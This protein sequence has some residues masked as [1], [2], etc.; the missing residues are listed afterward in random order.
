MTVF[1]PLQLL[2]PYAAIAASFAPYGTLVWVVSTLAWLGCRPPR[3][4]LL[5]A[6]TGAALIVHLAWTRP[7]WPHQ[8]PAS[9]GSTLTVMS[10]NMYYGWADLSQVAAEVERV[11]PDIVVLQEVTIQSV[12]GIEA[13][14]WR[15]R[16]PHR[17]GRPAADW[18]ATNMLVF[19]RYPLH[20]IA[21]A[22]ED[23]PIVVLRADVPGGP[24]T[25]VAVHVT[26]PVVDM[27]AW[28]SELQRAEDAVRRASGPTIALGD[29]NAVREHQPLRQ[30]LERTGLKDAAEEAGAGWIPTFPADS[31][32][33]LIS[34][35]HV[36]VSQDFVASFVGTIRVAGTDHLGLQAELLMP[37]R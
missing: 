36:L 5:A 31:L 12:E 33:P 11:Q 2:H 29:F 34:L 9:A 22:P 28:V 30:L 6:L 10:L 26:N 32:L 21:D 17:V 8:P 20:A 24:V 3:I 23:A 27:A 19:S 16:F 37:G 13:P 7:Y 14:G 15:A 1:P 25:L 18:V 4:K 35:D